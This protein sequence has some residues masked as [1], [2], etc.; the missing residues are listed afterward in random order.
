MGRSMSREILRIVST[1]ARQPFMRPVGEIQAEHVGPGQHELGEHFERAAGRPDRR[2]D[3]GLDVRQPFSLGQTPHP[4]LSSGDDFEKSDR[5]HA[6]DSPLPPV[7]MVS[8]SA[9]KAKNCVPTV[10]E[11]QTFGL[12]IFR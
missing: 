7:V 1:I 9:C 8:V 10:L 3:L 5:T 2:D 11:L 12:Q 6:Q 4:T